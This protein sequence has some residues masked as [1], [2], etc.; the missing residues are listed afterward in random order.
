MSLKI[1]YV[2]LDELTPYVNNAKEHPDSQV[3]QIVASI[4]EFGFNDPNIS[5]NTKKNNALS[6]F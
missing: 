4:K 2:G 6:F 1:E 5:I 3:D